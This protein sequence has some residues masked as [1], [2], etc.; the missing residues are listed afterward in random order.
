MSSIPGGD[1]VAVRFLRVSAEYECWP[2]WQDEPPF[3]VDPGTLPISDG[4]RRRLR[5]WS[6]KFALTL[7]ED[8]P[9]DSRFPTERLEMDFHA[10]GQA[11]TRAL[12]EELGQSVTVTYSPHSERD[13]R[14]E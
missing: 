11:L 6:A 7:D 2:L 5:E 1:D 3:N 13:M 8:Y 14:S 12:Q 10:E 4:L 9:P